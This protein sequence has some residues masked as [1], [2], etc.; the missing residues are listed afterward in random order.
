MKISP[1]SQNNSKQKTSFT[2]YVRNPNQPLL[3]KLIPDADGT[4][5]RAI[6]EMGVI[7]LKTSKY[8]EMIK[9]IFNP[10]YSIFK[11]D[12][13]KT[14]ILVK[15]EATKLD[16]ILFKHVSGSNFEETNKELDDLFT[17][18]ITEAEDIPQDTYE[19]WVEGYKALATKML[20]K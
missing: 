11:E 19:K 8:I 6:A 18:C 15:E 13:Q 14:I 20:G 7:D 5:G 17:K 16:N 2:S 1:I 9:K 10:D 3:E 12:T 4:I